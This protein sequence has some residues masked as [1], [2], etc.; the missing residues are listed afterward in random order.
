MATRKRRI[1]DIYYVQLRATVGELGQL[2]KPHLLRKHYKVKRGFVRYY[3]KKYALPDYHTK[4]WGAPYGND[5]GRALL[6]H[7]DE[8]LAQLAL[9]T[10]VKV[11]PQRTMKQFM[12]AVND[13]WMIPITIKWIRRVFGL[14][15]FTCKQ[16]AYR[17]TLKYTA[18]NNIYYV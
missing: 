4:P 10:E 11:N 16:A 6:S 15:R 17:A 2:V 5:N 9:W 3:T 8:Q 7:S 1:Q 14:W 12:Q 18:A 13:E